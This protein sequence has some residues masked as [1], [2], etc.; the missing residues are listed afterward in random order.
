MLDKIEINKR[1]ALI[2]YLYKLGSDAVNSGNVITKATCILHFHDAVEMLFIL[3]AENIGVGQKSDSLMEYFGKI[4]QA[5]SKKR[6]LSQHKLIDKLRLM[7]VDF[8]HHAIPPNEDA[9]LSLKSGL[10]NFFED[11]VFKF[12]EI[13][14]SDI[15]LAD[16]INDAEV[17]RIVREAEEHLKNKKYEKCLSDLGRAFHLLFE[18]SKM[19]TNQSFGNAMYLPSQANFFGVGMPREF[20][21]IFEKVSNKTYSPLAEALNVLIAGL[22]YKEYAK[23]KC[24]TPRF[25]QLMNGNVRE[26]G[27][28]TEYKSRFNLNLKNTEFCY[29]FL[30]NA[31]LKVEKFNFGLFPVWDKPDKVTIATGDIDLYKGNRT[32]LKKVGTV[33][34]GTIIK[35]GPTVMMVDSEEYREVLVNDVRGLIKSASA[36]KEIDNPELKLEG[37]T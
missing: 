30:I 24:L 17:R 7:R 37:E 10:D 22:D 3:I 21:D 1:L 27:Q 8:K 34:G 15:S 33:P 29:H 23:F 19:K 25:I 6:E 36:I 11:N 28:N 14:F 20:E 2:K 5:D 32:N 16:S 9:C 31:I 13:N 4:K 18:R 26:V 12:F 35:F